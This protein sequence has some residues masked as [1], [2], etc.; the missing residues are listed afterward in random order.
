VRLSATSLLLC[1]ICFTSLYSRA[2]R[3]A[4]RARAPKNT[5][6]TQPRLPACPVFRR[7]T[8][9]KAVAVRVSYIIHP[10]PCAAGGTT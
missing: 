2:G 7:Y 4:Y 3:L 6:Q 9:F 10:G 1:S 5:C 8:P